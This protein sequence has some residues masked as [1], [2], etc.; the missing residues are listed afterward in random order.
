MKNSTRTSLKDFSG[1]A[2]RGHTTISSKKTLCNSYRDY[3]RNSEWN[4]RIHRNF[5]RE[6]TLPEILLV[7]CLHQKLFHIHSSKDSTRKSS[8]DISKDY[9]RNFFRN[10]SNFASWDSTIKFIRIFTKNWART[11]FFNF[12]IISVSTRISAKGS[13]IIFFNDCTGVHP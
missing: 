8:R 3:T 11:S 7:K 4:F 2:S 5:Y 1:N 10:S 9:T 6:F 12:D 13:N